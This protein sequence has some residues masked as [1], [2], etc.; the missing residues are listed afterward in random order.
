M[1]RKFDALWS[2]P[3]YFKFDSG[4]VA[5]EAAKHAKNVPKQVMLNRRYGTRSA[6]FSEFP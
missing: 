3:F 4:K 2:F 5:A 6:I 1:F